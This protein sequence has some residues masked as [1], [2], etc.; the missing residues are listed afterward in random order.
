MTRPKHVSTPVRSRPGRRPLTGAL[1]LEERSAA[2]A[3][4]GDPGRK[5][6]KAALWAVVI[7]VAVGLLR[8]LLAGSRIA[9][10]EADVSGFTVSGSSV[11][12]FVLWAGTALVVLLLLA[13]IVRGLQGVL[14][15][16][17]SEGAARAGLVLGIVLVG[18]VG[19]YA[20]CGGFDE[21]VVAEPTGGQVQR[22]PGLYDQ[23]TGRYT[24]EEYRFKI[25]GAGPG[26]PL[27]ET[28]LGGWDYGVQFALEGTERRAVVEI[29]ASE[30]A[31]VS[32]TKAWAES[33]NLNA[34][35]DY[36]DSGQLVSGRTSRLN[37]LWC[38]VTRIRAGDDDDP[39]RCVEYRVPGNGHAYLVRCIAFEHDWPA[40]RDQFKEIAGTFQCW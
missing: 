36:S 29:Y 32:N 35:Q 15:G 20:I 19:V 2:R 30:R 13:A 34:M 38:G 16:E 28:D 10:S 37:G 8:W 39:L 11:A 18:V 1:N 26:H 4:R 22:Q 24:N 6:L 17:G 33:L 40:T 21:I 23:Q 5:G 9:L 3:P 14:R 27:E 7:A 12:R 25:K 31:K